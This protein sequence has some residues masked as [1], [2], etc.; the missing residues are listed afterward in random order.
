MHAAKALFGEWNAQQYA[1][2]NIFDQI[3]GS[4][5]CNLYELDDADIG[6]E[7]SR[8]PYGGRVVQ[9]EFDRVQKE[10]APH[11]FRLHNWGPRHQ[12]VQICGSFDSWEKRHEM[13]F[14]HIANQ[15]FATIHLPR[16]EHTYKYVINNEKWVVNEEERQVKD[17][18]GNVNNFVPL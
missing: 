6:A 5:K 7:A 12:I 16:G 18:L 13:Q 17:K 1:P 9:S 11:S 4:E 15:W 14:D 8:Q 2:I 10:R 3:I